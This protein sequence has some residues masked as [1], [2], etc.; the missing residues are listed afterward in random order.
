MH[1]KSLES[2]IRDAKAKWYEVDHNNLI[3]DRSKA[4]MISS[5]GSKPHFFS[6]E[7]ADYTYRILIE[8]FDEGALSISRDGLILYCNDYFSKMIGLPSNE[9][10]GTFFKEYIDSEEAFDTIINDL[11]G[12]PVKKE[13][14]LRALHSKMHVNVS[15][16]DL[17]P[18]VNAI[19]V[20]VTDLT[21]KRSNEEALQKNHAELEKK[22]T[23]LNHTNVNLEQFIHVIS[24]DLKE[25]IR[26]LVAYTSFLLEK[27]Q[28]EASNDDGH[29]LNI[30]NA[31]AVRL[32]S[33]VD[34]L[35][36]YS[37]TAV[38]E[39]V[40]KVD[41]NK[42]FSEVIE[43][44]ELL[45]N[46]N[47]AMIECGLLPPITGSK[48]QMRQL[49]S[50]LLSNAIKYK[51]DDI[52]PV[53]KITSELAKGFRGDEPEKVYHKITFSDNGI[54]MKSSHL[55]KIFTIFQRLHLRDEYSGNG[56]GLAICKKIMENHSGKIDVE[57]APGIGSQFNLYFPV[58]Q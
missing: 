37:Y 34:D 10:V 23:E 33:L 55:Q 13:L 21:E 16:T 41:L 44:I 38:K 5:K 35:V 12:R 54:G 45:I 28:A 52:P 51:K 27:S 30:I 18:N 50:S 20:V 40:R 7:S 9:I 56:I 26:K 32:N 19:G 22:I 43:D 14:L 1:S 47:G 3:K 8:K 39:N 42:I 17:S 25:P 48:V 4:A 29:C 11:L 53:I 58:D 15:M 49:I 31:S 46:E 36:K 6:I 24:H 57:S 2:E